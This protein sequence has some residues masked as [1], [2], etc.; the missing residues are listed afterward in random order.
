[1]SIQTEE[2][3]SLAFIWVDAE[4]TKQKKGVNREEMK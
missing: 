1:M 2:D 3:P 4:E